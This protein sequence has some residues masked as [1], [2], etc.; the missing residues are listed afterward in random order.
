[1]LAIRSIIGGINTEMDIMYTSVI[2]AIVIA[3]LLA[4]LT[5]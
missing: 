4:I 1:M 3:I 2:L 5:K